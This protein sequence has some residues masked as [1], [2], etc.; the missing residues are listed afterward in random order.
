MTFART[1]KGTHFRASPLAAAILTLAAIPSPLAADE[2]LYP[3]IRIMPLGDS[4]TRGNNDIN[5]PNGD[6]PGG[7]RLKLGNLLEDSSIDFNFVGTRSDNAATGMDPHHNG[8]PGWRTDEILSGLPG[9]LDDAPD[10]VLLKAG[11]NDI[12][13][14]I[15]VATAIA[16]LNSIITTI[17]EGDPERKLYV[18]TI[19][20]ITQQWPPQGNGVPAS[21]LNADVDA[22]NT[23]LRARVQFYAD[24]GLNVSL[25]DLNATLDYTGGSGTADDFFQ[26]G[27]GVHPGK[28]G[29]DQMADL[30]H[31]AISLDYPFIPTAEGSPPPPSDLTLSV[32]SPSRINLSWTD[33][34]SNEQV[35]QITRKIG[36]DGTWQQLATVAADQTTHA[37]TGLQ[38]A[39]HPYGF[40]VRAGN[41]NGYSIW[42]G[43]AWSPD[44]VD[45]A[46]AKPASSSTEADP[47]HQAPAANDTNPDTSWSS[48]PGDT[49]A[50]WQVDLQNDYRIQR[51]ELTTRQDA[52]NE[53]ERKNF[54]IRASQ[55]PSFA[56][57]DVLASQ[58]ATPLDHASTWTA[59][60]SNPTAFRYIR[61]AKTDAEPFSIALVKV[62]AAT[63]PASPAAPTDLAA[64]PLDSNHVA[65]TWTVQSANESGFTL[66][67]MTGESGTWQPIATLPATTTAHQ[68]ANL[69]ADTTY[70]YRIRS[71]NESGDSAP[72]AEAQ[73]TTGSTTA[74]DLWTAGHPDFLALPPADRIP[75]ADPNNDGIANLLAYSFGIDP[76]AD[77]SGHLPSLTSPATGDLTYQ[78][79]RNTL[80]PDVALDLLVSEDMSDGS[81]A[82]HPLTGSSVTAA[83][84][85]PDAEIISLPII[86]GST[87]PTRFYRLRAVRPT[88]P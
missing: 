81:W 65:L 47:S 44:P 75:T 68:D 34:S 21:V 50:H 9:W 76:L 49:S 17:T 26:P 84:G 88:A 56:T 3:T 85:N 54:E 52:D 71:T 12:L 28:A 51:V 36:T 80:A 35:F 53:P 42:S 11:T 62:F 1:N 77:A 72:S 4:I 30:W 15:P 16:N 46:D 78:F 82:P 25:V 57:F 79:Q 23:Q 60:V 18:A 45:A 38:T 31:A 7:Y 29:Y 74:W 20:P 86:P 37:V 63:L 22:Y 58:G 6:I 43:I 2:F 24:Q 8:N 61:I 33:N 73:A 41:G 19:V 55:D 39:V 66:E 5:Y 67:R 64:T 87:P 10:V 48:D 32:V 59:D 83:P 13:Q 69:A 40:A 14:R 70:N 27:D